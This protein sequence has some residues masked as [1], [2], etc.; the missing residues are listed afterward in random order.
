[1]SR[2]FDEEFYFII[3]LLI[4]LAAAVISSLAAATSAVITSAGLTPAPGIATAPG[5]TATSAATGEVARGIPTG[6]P[7][8]LTGIIWVIAAGIIAVA[9]VMIQCRI[10]AGGITIPSIITDSSLGAIRGSRT[11]QVTSG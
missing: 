8:T 5:T 4:S 3:P 7:I 6:H 2:L 10:V 11:P 9:P 1:M